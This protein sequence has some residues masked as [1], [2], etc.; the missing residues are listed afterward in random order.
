MNTKEFLL[1]IRDRLV[2]V[3]TDIAEDSEMNESP[4]V[5]FVQKLQDWHTLKDS[6]SGEIVAYY[7]PKFIK[8]HRLANQMCHVE[9]V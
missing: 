3:Y 9:K 6:D 2:N 8:L 1:W 4:L 7:N 5:D